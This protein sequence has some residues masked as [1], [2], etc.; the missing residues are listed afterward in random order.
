MLLYVAAYIQIIPGLGWYHDRKF[1]TSVTGVPFVLG[2]PQWAY[3]SERAFN[4]DGHSIAAYTIPEDALRQFHSKGFP[5]GPKRTAFRN[6][7][8]VIKWK[9][10]PVAPEDTPYVDFALRSSDSSYEANQL[11]T[12]GMNALNAN[13]TFYAYLHKSRTFDDGDLW[14]LNVDFYII[15]LENGIFI[16]VNHNT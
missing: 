8:T 11:S 14:I 9:C 4:G 6:D 2:E 13:S 3:D 15:D 7:W 1:T 12:M 16:T 5:F 10:G